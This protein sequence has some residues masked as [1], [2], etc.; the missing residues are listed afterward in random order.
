M[1]SGKKTRGRARGGGGGSVGRRCALCGKA[2]RLVRTECC[3]QW[4]CDD[5]SEY[6]LF[7]Y[8]RNSCYRNHRRYTLCGYHHAE[9]HSGT[10][11]DCSSCRSEFETELYVYYGTNEFNFEKLENPPAYQPTRCSTCDTIIRL[12]EDGYSIQGSRYLC[13]RCS[14]G[15]S[16]AY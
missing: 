14:R 12:G 5:E 1:A 15:S 10:W 9:E 8:A 13:E 11:K 16:D 4:I 7:S 2:R 3:G 6:V